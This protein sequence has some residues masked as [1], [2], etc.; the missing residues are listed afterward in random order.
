ML[1]NPLNIA[2][3]DVVL[4]LSVL[5]VDRLAVVVDGLS[6]KIKVSLCLDHCLPDGQQQQE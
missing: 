4:K 6:F 3:G 1:E 2:G 5:V